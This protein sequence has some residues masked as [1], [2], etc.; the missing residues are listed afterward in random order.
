MSDIE[1]TWD[2]PELADGVRQATVKAVEGRT[3]KGGDPM[4]VV[5]FKLTGG[6]EIQDFI[7]LDGAGKSMGLAKLERLGVPKGA[8]K[9][10]TADLIGRQLSIVCIKSEYNG[11]EQ[12]KI[13]G[14]ANQDPYRLGY[15]RDVQKPDLDSVPF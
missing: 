4:V 8:A 12:L 3:S 6:G 10:N 15:G 2:V 1:L 5:T 11:R 9:L 14:K 7:M 13:D